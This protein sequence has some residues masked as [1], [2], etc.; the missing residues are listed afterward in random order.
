MQLLFYDS[1][2]R[3]HSFSYGSAGALKDAGATS[4]GDVCV[5]F[6]HSDKTHRLVSCQPFTLRG[7]RGC[8]GFLSGVSWDII[9]C[10]AVYEQETRVRDRHFCFHT[11]HLVNRSSVSTSFLLAD[12]MYHYH[13]A[14][15]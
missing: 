8:M 9:R 11:T 7:E 12:I 15:I 14:S 2:R 3:W 1:H 13:I 4:I 6:H 10:A 5:P